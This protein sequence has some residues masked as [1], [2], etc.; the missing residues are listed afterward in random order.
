MAWFILDLTVL[1]VSKI[2]FGMKKYT[3]IATVTE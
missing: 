3:I 2:V 1:V